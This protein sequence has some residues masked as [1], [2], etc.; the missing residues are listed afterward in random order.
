MWGRDMKCGESTSTVVTTDICTGAGKV[1]G[2]GTFTGGRPSK[3]VEII[4]KGG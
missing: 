1:P 3:G 4:I 2:T